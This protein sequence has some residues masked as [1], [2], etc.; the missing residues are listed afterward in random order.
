[1]DVL[2][3]FVWC[4]MLSPPPCQL[5]DSDRFPPP[6]ICY[7]ALRFNAEYQA[8]LCG[9]MAWNVG[10]DTSNLHEAY[11]EAKRVWH[12]WDACNGGIGG[13]E[14]EHQK[15]TGY[16]LYWLGRLRDMIGEEAY[17]AGRLPPSVPL[18]F[19]GYIR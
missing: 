15:S 11:D 5:S 17:L 10:R 16:R 9:K 6:E 2:T 1:M 14:G 13:E 8:D 19:F 12:V 4:A 3:A 18:R 7:A